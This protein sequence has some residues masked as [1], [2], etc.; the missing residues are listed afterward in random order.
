VFS[1]PAV[2]VSTPGVLRGAKNLRVDTAF[3]GSLKAMDIGTVLVEFL[4]DCEVSSELR[5]LHYF[6]SRKSSSWAVDSCEVLFNESLCFAY[7]LTAFNS[8]SVTVCMP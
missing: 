2:S 7:V 3:G 6:T 4:A 5:L 1:A 8:I